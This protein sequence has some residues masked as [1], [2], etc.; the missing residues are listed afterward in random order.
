ML[1]DKGMLINC[2]NKLLYCP[3]SFIKKT[4]LREKLLDPNAEKDE[5]GNLY[6]RACPLMLEQLIMEYSY[7]NY[8]IEL[9]VYKDILRGNDKKK[10]TIKKRNT[11]N[12]ELKTVNENIPIKIDKTTTCQYIKKTFLKNYD[13]DNISLHYKSFLN[14]EQKPMDY[15]IKENDVIMC[16]ILKG[17][18]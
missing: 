13:P 14:P 11:I 2:R 12:V 6:I 4:N 1:K 18:Q 17:D 16:V 3:E 5:K 10:N 7:E 9:K 15:G 8:E